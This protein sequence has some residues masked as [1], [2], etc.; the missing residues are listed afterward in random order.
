MR[1][2]VFGTLLTCWLSALPLPARGFDLTGTWQGTQVCK[3]TTADGKEKQVFKEDVLTITQS[4]TEVRIYMD[5]L[6]LLYTGVA[7]ANASH[8]EKGAVAFRLCGLSEDTSTEGEMGNAQVS[9]KAPPKK[10]QFQATSIFADDE[11][12]DTCT[13]K[14]QRTATADPGVPACP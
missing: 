4:G 7:F 14:Y 9:T 13:W 12:V 10:S 11:E 1:T 6:D 2:F 3:L 8:P 5:S